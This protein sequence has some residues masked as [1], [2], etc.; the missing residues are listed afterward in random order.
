MQVYSVIVIADVEV[1]P[2]VKLHTHL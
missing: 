1:F 2:A